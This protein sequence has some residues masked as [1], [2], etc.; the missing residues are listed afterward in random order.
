M[1][2]QFAFRR[3]ALHRIEAACVPENAASQRLLERARFRPE[4]QARGY[5][6]INGVWRDHLLY[7]LLRDDA[8]ETP[9]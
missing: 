3:L 5:L 7:G 8:S 6:K 2:T 1:A 4:G 9:S